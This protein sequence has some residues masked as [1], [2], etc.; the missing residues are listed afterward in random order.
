MSSF[1]KSIWE[2]PV[3]FLS[4]GDEKIGPLTWNLTKEKLKITPSLGVGADSKGIIFNG[5][6]D[7]VIG[8]G[9][10]HMDVD[11]SMLKVGDYAVNPLA[12]E[13]ASTPISPMKMFEEDASKYL[14]IAILSRAILTCLDDMERKEYNQKMV[15]TYEVIDYDSFQ[16][17]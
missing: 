6:D 3:K 7:V 4:G 9:S 11:P 15:Y 2:I 12:T 8:A 17:S 5:N 1:L 13:V 16:P 14:Y 10:I